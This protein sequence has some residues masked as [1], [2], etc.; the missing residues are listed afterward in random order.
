MP[1]PDEGFEWEIVTQPEDVSGRLGFKTY[2]GLGKFI[3]P[4]G[5][6]PPGEVIKLLEEEKSKR[7]PGQ[8]IVQEV[9][10]TEFFLMGNELWR[11]K[12]QTSIPP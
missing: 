6:L 9:P 10:M 3:F 8:V 5:V 1:V 12:I 4:R 7:I 2:L 11:M